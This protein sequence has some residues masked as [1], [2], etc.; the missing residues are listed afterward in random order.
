MRTFIF[1]LCMM[2]IAS[3]TREE[4]PTTGN[5]V[6]PVGKTIIDSAD[7]ESEKV[8]GYLENQFNELF[9]A[10]FIV[11]DTLIDEI[12][13]R[14]SSGEEVVIFYQAINQDYIQD[15]SGMFWEED[16]IVPAEGNLEVSHV[17]D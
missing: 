13:V 4:I 15:E 16:D 6:E 11:P 8:F 10:E 3:C 7:L 5:Y 1:A 17:D 2:A 14:I 12:S 9:L